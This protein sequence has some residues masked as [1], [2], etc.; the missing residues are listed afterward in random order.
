MHLLNIELR[1]RICTHC[2][3]VAKIIT[4]R[5]KM[6]SSQASPIPTTTRIR[7]TILGPL[8]RDESKKAGRCYSRSRLCDLQGAGLGY[9]LGL[10]VRAIP[11]PP[12]PSPRFQLA[13]EPDCMLVTPYSRRYS[14]IYLERPRLCTTRIRTYYAEGGEA[15]CS[16][17]YGRH[18]WLHWVAL[19]LRRSN[20]RRRSG[21]KRSMS[22]TCTAAATADH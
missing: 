10:Y 19:V 14:S 16:T 17:A 22:R 18:I 5:A 7:L 3:S 8:K 6:Y 13:P 4:M 20:S 2:R 15:H 9:I 12:K 1:Y 21:Y 11:N